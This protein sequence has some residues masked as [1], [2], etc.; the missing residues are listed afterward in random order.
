MRKIR[1]ALRLK[2]AL[3][4]SERQIAM[5]VG[6][7]RSTVAKYLRRAGMVGIT[8]PVPEGMDDAVLEQ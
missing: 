2:H 5:S 4:Q 3:G 6:M 8:C 7:S 1:K